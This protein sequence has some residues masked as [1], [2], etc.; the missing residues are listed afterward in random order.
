[1]L[2]LCGPILGLCWGYVGPS[3]RYVEAMLTHVGP[4]LSHLV[5]YVG[6]WDT[7]FGP[8]FQ[9]LLEKAPAS[10]LGGTRSVF[11]TPFF[12]KTWILPGT[13]SPPRSSKKLPPMALRC[14]GWCVEPTRRVVAG[15]ARTPTQ[16]GIRARDQ[17]GTVLK[18]PRGP[19]R[20]KPTHFTLFREFSGNFST[21]KASP[22]PAPEA[23]VG[24]VSSRSSHIPKR[25]PVNTHA[26]PLVLSMRLRSRFPSGVGGFCV[27]F[28]HTTTYPW[29]LCSP[30]LCDQFLVKTKRKRTNNFSAPRWM[31]L[32]LP[33]V[34]KWRCRCGRWPQK[35]KSHSRCYTNML[36]VSSRA[37]SQG[38]KHAQHAQL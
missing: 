25:S 21:V 13:G 34:V 9:I 27:A 12:S 20:S 7:P 29:C 26:A 5:G 1:M 8:C 14:Q 18:L 2:V 37:F 17:P 19:V 6:P 35:I 33:K 23:G 38:G 10:G 4:M 15:W 22:K 32:H 3:W 31:S 28:H 24:E 16:A 36:Q 11:A 30:K